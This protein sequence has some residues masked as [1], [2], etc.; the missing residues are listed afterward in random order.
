MKYDPE[1]TVNKDIKDELEKKLP[2]RITSNILCAG[3]EV[4]M[5]GSR[6]KFNF[7]LPEY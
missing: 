5:F 7:T 2:N 4:C 1:D 6:Q 3:S